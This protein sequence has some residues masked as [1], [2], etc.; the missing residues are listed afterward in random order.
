[1]AVGACAAKEG[2]VSRGNVARGEARKHTLDLQFAGMGRQIERR[3][4]RGLRYVPEQIVDRGNADGLQ[5]GAA[6]FRRKREI[7]HYTLRLLVMAGLVP[8]I[9]EHRQKFVIMDRRDKPGDD[10]FILSEISI[11]SPLGIPCTDL[12]SSIS[13]MTRRLPVSS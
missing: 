6:V 7:A 1:M 3:V 2:A 9:H 12:L 4:T 11:I 5:H 10:G 8:A 13:E